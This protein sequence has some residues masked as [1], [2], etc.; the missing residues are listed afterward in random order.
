MTQL[1]KTFFEL[2][3]VDSPTGEEMA[4]AELVVRKLAE[5]G[6]IAN[7]QAGASYDNAADD[8]SYY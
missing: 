2:I 5:M 1:I 3:K 8:G 6:I 4:V 7:N